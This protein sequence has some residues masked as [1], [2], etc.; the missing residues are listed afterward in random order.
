[1]NVTEYTYA[2]GYRTHVLTVPAANAIA[3]CFLFHG[4]LEHHERYFEFAQFLAEN[5]F[6]VYVCDMRGAGALAR[7]Q[8]TYAHLL[9][10]EGFNQMVDDAM[11][12]IEHHGGTLPTFVLGHSFGSLLSRRLGQVMGHRLA[13]VVAIS[14]PPG[15][16]VV[17]RIGRF[18]IDA[19]M[20]RKGSDYP[21]CFFERL[22]FGRYNL[23][24]L[25]A[26]T[27][28]DWISS[29][30][31]EVASYL[32][33]ENC[34]G[35]PTLGYLYEVT[36]AS[37][38]VTS[39]P[40]IHEHP[41][42]LPLLF[43]VGADDPVVSDGEGLSGIVRNYRSADVELTVLSYDGARHEVLREKQREEVWNDITAW[44]LQLTSTPHGKTSY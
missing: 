41:K 5:G 4:M 38:D 42:S 23:K 32:N 25:P 33:D 19:A 39:L 29:D 22:L 24:F 35:L 40:R 16:G 11:T 3:D 14:P 30:P 7:T 37:L 34:G 18:A 8:E 9:P 21:S 10:K 27:E 13:G 26:K 17:G 36:S 2:D 15:S 28:S 44:M 31:E 1:M 6:N 20:R 43:V 12:L